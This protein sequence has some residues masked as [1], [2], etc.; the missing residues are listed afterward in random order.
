M[1]QRRKAGRAGRQRSAI[2]ALA[3]YLILSPALC[4]APGTAQALDWDRLWLNAD[5]RGAREMKEKH[6]AAAARTFRDK[7]WQAA[8]WYRAGQYKRSAEAWAKMDDIDAHYN[9]GNALARLGDFKRAAEEYR[10]VLERDPGNADARHN[11]EVVEKMMQHRNQTGSRESRSRKEVNQQ[12]GKDRKSKPGDSGAGGNG[13]QPSGGNPSRTQQASGSGQQG[14]R[15][16]SAGV[17]KHRRDAQSRAANRSGQAKHPGGQSASTA[18]QGRGMGLSA[19]KEGGRDRNRGGAAGALAESQTPEQQ[20]AM[21]QWLRR[22]PDDPGGL[23]RRKFRYEYQQ[24]RRA[25]ERLEK[26]W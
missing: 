14:S 11:L 18:R 20:A 9:R 25:H 19:G 5:Q 12:Q 17:D 7:R 24:R 1:I 21:E 13:H 22:I 2:A 16:Q 4:L 26:P 15:N 23:L 8:A 10:T 6:Y 3:L